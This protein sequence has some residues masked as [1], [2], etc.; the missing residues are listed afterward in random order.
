MHDRTKSIGDVGYRL[1][2]G[3]AKHGTR[4]LVLALLVA[5][6]TGGAAAE[7]TELLFETQG[8]L[9]NGDNGPHPD[10]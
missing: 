1:G 9:V 3:F 10:E 8:E 6:A 5:L 4:L 7:G 2:V